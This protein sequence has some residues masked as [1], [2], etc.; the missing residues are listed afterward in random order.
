MD[1]VVQRII[2]NSNLSKILKEQVY[3][4]F[5]EY[6]NTY[7]YI[8]VG[9]IN[10][11]I[12]ELQLLEKDLNKVTIDNETLKAIVYTFLKRYLIKKKYNKETDTHDPVWERFYQTI[13]ENTVLNNFNRKYF[14]TLEN[15][16]TSIIDFINKSSV[17]VDELFELMKN[18]QSFLVLKKYQEILEFCNYLGIDP[19]IFTDEE[20]LKQAINKKFSIYSSINL[21]TYKEQ[22]K[23]RTLS[24]KTS[25]KPDD[26]IYNINDCLETNMLHK[27]LH[28]IIK[29]YYQK[30][31][32]IMRPYNKNINLYYLNNI[33]VVAYRYDDVPN[34]SLKSGNLTLT[35]KDR[36]FWTKVFNPNI[37]YVEGGSINYFIDTEEEQEHYRVQSQTFDTTFFQSLGT[38]VIFTP[39]EYLEEAIYKSLTENDNLPLDQKYIKKLESYGLNFNNKTNNLMTSNYSFFFKDPTKVDDLEVENIEEYQYLNMIKSKTD[40]K[41]RKRCIITLSTLSKKDPKKP[42]PATK[43]TKYYQKKINVQLPYKDN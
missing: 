12:Q 5:E 9:D 23:R 26:F 7:V 14:L 31:K 20:K 40:P 13:I 2:N 1:P 32:F 11:I 29:K 33:V 3:I 18:E 25:F 19:K 6:L 37:D 30:T 10:E 41:S 17:L 36:D 35:Y 38:K 8:S 15:P 16:N 34:T 42:E 39:E 27:Q 24:K 21:K 28:E 4:L 43:K 22:V